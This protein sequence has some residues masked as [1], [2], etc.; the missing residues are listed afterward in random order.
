MTDIKIGQFIKV[1]NPKKLIRDYLIKTSINNIDIEKLIVLCSIIEGKK[2]KVVDVCKTCR[3]VKIKVGKLYLSLN[4][5][6]I[7]DYGKA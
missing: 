1:V 5:R 3:I 2:Y 6:Y 7:A 4:F